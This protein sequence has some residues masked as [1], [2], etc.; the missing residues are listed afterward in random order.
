MVNLVVEPNVALGLGLP[1]GDFSFGLFLVAITGATKSTKLIAIVNDDAGRRATRVEDVLLRVVQEES[2]DSGSAAWTMA[3]R[4]GALAQAMGFAAVEAESL[5]A[6]AR[7]RNEGVIN[8][9]AA[10]LRRTYGAKIARRRRL[11][12]EARNEL[13]Q[14]LRA[15]EIRNLETELDRRLSEL[16]RGR[17]V[18]FTIQEIGAGRLSIRHATA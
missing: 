15:G 18:G 10:S 13:I 17:D 11:R 4:D 6:D 7:Q 3:Q 5:V 9:R 16:E 12:D 14:R 8:L 1:S 2:A